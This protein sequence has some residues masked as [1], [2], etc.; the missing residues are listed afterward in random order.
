MHGQQNIKKLI[1]TFV[2]HMAQ[3]DGVQY[4]KD[5]LDSC[6]GYSSHAILQTC[7]FLWSFQNFSLRIFWTSV[8][9]T[10][11]NTWLLVFHLSFLVSS[12][13]MVH[14]HYLH[15]PLYLVCVWVC[16]VLGHVHASYFVPPIFR[17]QTPHNPKSQCYPVS[18]AP[19]HH[20][21]MTKHLSLSALLFL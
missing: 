11:L 2:K 20:H 17:S 15:F 19:C 7:F 6:C 13:H 14:Q 3:N 8:I 16:E 4:S 18:P 1:I 12:I 5:P 21:L 9:C 10:N